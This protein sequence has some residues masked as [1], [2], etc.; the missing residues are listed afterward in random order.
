MSRYVGLS[1]ILMHFSFLQTLY[2]EILLLSYYV[3][4]MYANQLD[5]Q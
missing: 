4:A 1:Y 3:I 2:K 5:K